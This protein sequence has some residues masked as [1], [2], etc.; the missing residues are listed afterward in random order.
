M[1]AKGWSVAL[2]RPIWAAPLIVLL[3]LGGCDGPDRAASPAMVVPARNY[4][5]QGVVSEQVL[6]NYLSRAV[7]HQTLFTDGDA[8]LLRDD[9]RMFKRIG[10]KF[11]GRASI[12]WTTPD[13]LDFF[14]AR[15]AEIAMLVHEADKEIILQGGVFETVDAG[16][17]RAAVPAWV[18]QDFG[19]P[20]EQRN[21]RYEDMLYLDGRYVDFWGPSASVPDIA[22]LETRMWYYYLAARYL[23]S[24][25]EA[26]HF[27]VVEIVSENDPGFEAYFD[28]LDRLRLRASRQA[29]RGLVLCDAH[30]NRGVVREG[31]SLFDFVS[32]PLRIQEVDE[33]PRQGRLVVGAGDAI[34]GQTIGGL[35]PSGWPALR[36]PYLVEVDNWGSSGQGGVDIGGIWIWGWDEIDWFARLREPERND[37]LDYAWHWV[38]ENDSFG[39]F[40]FP[41]RRI[42]ADPIDDA[43]YWYY[44]NRP[45]PQC[46]LGFNQEE[47]MEAIWKADY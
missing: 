44:A 1:K 30:H 40:Q 39:R 36:L 35:T 6:M 18:F 15:A 27:G 10:A 9:I 47:A 23:D 17:A 29:R 41:T 7:S 37:W 19:R 43:Y 13:D 14:F 28:L 22:R 32:Y 3:I 34:Y 33:I 16:V 31:R 21:F 25:F 20:V 8:V 11:I 45:S 46:Q 12:V 4:A 26:I 24:G 5:F 38:R 2:I 42:L